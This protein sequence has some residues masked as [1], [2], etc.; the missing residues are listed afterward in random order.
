[1][2]PYVKRPSSSFWRTAVADRHMLDMKDLWDPK[3]DIRLEQPVVTFGSCFAQHIGR[4]LYARGF[5]WMIAEK[6]PLGL[7][8]KNAK[9]FNY[10]I[11]SA[12]TGNIY[13]TGLLEQW[14]SWA[15]GA[16]VQPQEVWEK[17]GRFFDPFRP[18]VE[19]DGF[20][21][22][23]ELRASRDEA[24]AAFKVCIEKAKYFVFTLGL[25]ESWVNEPGQYE[26]PMCPGTA[27]GDFDPDIHKFI[28]QDF[29]TILQSLASSMTR[30]MKVNPGLKFLLTV[31]PVPLTATMSDKHVL[32]ATMHSKSI[33][34][35]VAGQLAANRSNVDYFPSYEIVSS[36]AFRG[37]F[38]EPNQRDVNYSGVDFV[39]NT[40]F[41][42]LRGKF[43]EQRKAHV[44]GT[45]HAD[46][47]VVCEEELLAAFGA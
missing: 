5:K 28:N 29:S 16:V 24:I 10:G 19:K 38:F 25:T 35:A 45:R 42:C 43:G 9:A 14:T 18:R 1:M 37:V 41:E 12:R 22:V 40:F 6:A 33:L 21:S 34:R 4:S 3:F 30:M 47:D 11:F 2:N 13:T 20:E 36:P 23:A 26:Y 7:S 39:M 32:V 44:G 31:S 46:Q 17:D 8:Q 27:A 15:I